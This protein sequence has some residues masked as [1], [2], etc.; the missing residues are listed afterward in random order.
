M[1]SLSAQSPT[2]P[3]LEDDIAQTRAWLART[4]SPVE[5]DYVRSDPEL[6][7]TNS[8]PPLSSQEAET[9]RIEEVCYLHISLT[10]PTTQRP[11]DTPPVG[12]RGKTTPKGCSGINLVN[13]H[14]GF[15]L[16]TWRRH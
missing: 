9:R 3:T 8:Y 7:E 16:F 1:N 2:T 10:N 14:C 13:S 4:E 6:S 12:D 11:A 15:L 5:D